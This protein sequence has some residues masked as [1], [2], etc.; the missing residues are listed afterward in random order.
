MKQPLRQAVSPD[1]KLAF[2]I[3]Y[4]EEYSIGFL[5]HA[6]HTHGDILVPQYGPTAEAAAHAFFDSVIEDRQLICVSKEAGKDER[7]WITDDPAIDV[8]YMQPGET[9]QVRFW[10]GKE[11]SRHE[12]K[13]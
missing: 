6:W 7:I 10:S 12:K 8:Q 11:I 1:R 2:G 4:D 9:L 3:V 5:D 13:G